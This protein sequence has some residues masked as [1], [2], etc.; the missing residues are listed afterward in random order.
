MN[1]SPTTAVVDNLCDEVAPPQH[2]VKPIGLADLRARMA[3]GEDLLLVMAM[4]QRR[5]ETAHIAGSVSFDTVLA[6]RPGLDRSRE[7]VVY[8]TGPQCAASKLRAAFLVD[9]GFTDVS[10]FA[11]GL[12]EWSQ[13]GLPLD[14]TLARRPR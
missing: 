11:G 7:V 8:C 1:L 6:E 13:A 5:F 2:G 12:A 14:G 10:R 4:D 3:S 9:S